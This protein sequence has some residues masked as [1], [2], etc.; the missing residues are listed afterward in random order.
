M[1]RK[2][3]LWMVLM[4]WAIAFSLFSM[5]GIIEFLL[6]FTWPFGLLIFYF[7]VTILICIVGA[8]FSLRA[9]RRITTGHLSI[10]ERIDQLERAINDDSRE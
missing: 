1:N 4:S 3:K 6:L 9:I 5:F 8:M 10:E 2:T 7:N